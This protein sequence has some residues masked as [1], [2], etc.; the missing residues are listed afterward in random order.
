LLL[1]G[2]EGTGKRGFGKVF[3]STLD[4]KSNRN[5]ASKVQEY[6]LSKPD[7]RRRLEGVGEG[8]EEV[9]VEVMMEEGEKLKINL[10]VTKGLG[11]D[12]L[13]VDRRISEIVKSV[14]ARL[15]AALA[16]VSFFCVINFLFL[17]PFKIQDID[18]IRMR[19][20]TSRVRSAAR[21]SDLLVHLVIYFIS[22]TSLVSSPSPSSD[23]S[24]QSSEY[25][26]LRMSDRD[27]IA[28]KRLSKVSNV[29][30]VRPF[31]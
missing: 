2:N 16:A 8:G 26:G 1:V 4:T 28:I 18:V 6:F 9:E 20:E 25:S 31:L 3:L 14:E 23:K 30:P 27:L 11:G 5:S 15:E 24:T 12:D 21:L 17:C 29:L 10:V 19:Q 7:K 13:E 22:P